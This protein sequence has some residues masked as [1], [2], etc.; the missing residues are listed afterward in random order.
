VTASAPLGIL[1]GAASGFADEGF[2]E[3]TEPTRLGEPRHVGRG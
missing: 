2:D 3:F 1:I